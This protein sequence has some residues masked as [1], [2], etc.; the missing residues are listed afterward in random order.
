MSVSGPRI[1]VWPVWPYGPY[2]PYG[3]GHQQQGKKLSKRVLV[4]WREG[5]R[6]FFSRSRMASSISAGVTLS[7]GSQRTTSGP[8]GTVSSPD[9]M[10]ALTRCRDGDSPSP[11]S[12]VKGSSLRTIPSIS[13]IPRTSSMP[14]DWMRLIPAMARSPMEVA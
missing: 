6:A 2:G 8:A 7:G 11:R 9:F 3:R 4:R 10:S 13:P 14:G 12:G 1:P 5:A